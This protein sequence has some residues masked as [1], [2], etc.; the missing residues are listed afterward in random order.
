MSRLPARQTPAHPITAARIDPLEPRL[1][2]SGT[3]EIS[4]VTFRGVTGDAATGRYNIVVR[5]G[6]NFDAIAG[7]NGFSDVSPLG[8]NT[9]SF[10]TPRTPASIASWARKAAST[11]KAIFPD[12]VLTT[13]RAPNDTLYSAQYHLNNTGQLN[14]SPLLVPTTSDNRIFGTVGEDIDAEQAWNITTGSPDVVIAILDTGL[15]V[16]HGDILPNVWVNPGETAGDGIDND[17][18]GFVDDI[19]GYD[20]ADDD[21]DLT[22]T[23]GHGTAVAGVASA[24][25]NNAKG[26]TGVSWNSKLLG[27]KVFG[28]RTATSVRSAFIAG[29]NYIAD[30]KLRGV[31]VVAA[32]ASLGGPAFFFDPVVTAT[33]K[34]TADVGIVFVGAAGNTSSDNDRRADFPTRDSVNVRA[35]ISVASS[36]NLGN[37]SDFSSFG[38]T[39]V[40]VAAPGTAIFTTYSRSAPGASFTDSAGDTYIN[41]DGTSFSAPIVAGIVALAKSA[42]PNATAT[43][44]RDAIVNGVDVLP[45]LVGATERGPRKV[46]SGGRVNAFKTLQLLSAKVVS[47]NDATAGDWRGRFGSTAS[48]VYGATAGEP[49]FPGLT[50]SLTPAGATVVETRTRAR[51]NAGAVFPVGESRSNSMLTSP[52]AMAFNFDFTAT[53]PQRLSLYFADLDRRNRSQ[54]VRL[55]NTDTGFE[56]SRTNVSRF[57]S[58]RYVTLDLTGKVTVEIVPNGRSTAALN[59]LFLDAVP[60]TPTALDSVDTL[61]SGNWLNTYG[62]LGQILPGQTVAPPAFATFSTPAR[63]LSSGRARDPLQPESLISAR[64]RSTG[65]FTDPSGAPFDLTLNLTGGARQV[66]FYTSNSSRTTR[67]QRF[68]VI[69]PANGAVVAQ[70]DLTLSRSGA[71][72]TFTLS[73][74]NIVRVHTLGG[75]PASVSGVFFNSVNTAVAP[76]LTS[77]FFL[78]SNSKLGGRWRGTY[79]SSGQFV[80]GA[81]TSFPSFVSSTPTPTN[82]SF[83][84]VNANTRNPAAPQN[85]NLPSGGGIVGYLQTTGTSDLNIN[86]SD[87][88]TRRLTAYFTDFDRQ[89]RV[90]QVE[91]INPTTGE[92]L[93]SQTL[94][95]FERGKYLSWEVTGNVSLRITR[96]AGPTAVL[97]AVFFD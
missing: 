77:A 1:F 41:I 19:N 28:D 47:T 56:L 64:D 93:S 18:N 76:T 24:A 57:Q 44:I 59:A 8:N 68:Q 27:V 80:V 23:D 75:G 70:R 52:Q 54:I 5:P 26:V 2:L 42:F 10:F 86:V 61:T 31:N 60:T 96:I 62:D 7:R 25:G 63:V 38:N 36:D 73:G 74:N 33:L 88:S 89:S 4:S 82:A 29:L 97:S 32:N 46:S 3:P 83:T 49:T 6:A 20:L 84:I 16:A 48:F 14:P 21:A 87:G 92:V 17:G 51:S 78:D 72:A 53:G 94:R 15:D 40:Q 45:S 11:V 95:Q 22:D 35:N 43:E 30:L 12:F 13:Q 34:R 39:T 50:S 65:A 58:G 91:I 37:L 69:N 55:V 67:I 81:Q 66:S 9:Y 79:G 85:P 90:Q 71:Y